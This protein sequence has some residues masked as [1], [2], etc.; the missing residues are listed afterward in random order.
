[1]NNFD[2]QCDFMGQKTS[3]TVSKEH[4]FRR[5]GFPIDYEAEDA[6]L[7]NINWTYSWY[8]A[9]AK[10]WAYVYT[11][12]TRVDSGV[13]YI[14]GRSFNAQKIAKRFDKYQVE[15]A[16]LLLAT[17][18]EEVD[19]QIQQLWKSNYPD[20]SFFLDALA[21]T[22]TESIVKMA[23]QRI[24]QWA[25]LKAMKALSRYS[26][27]YPGW[28][29][30]DQIL[31][32]NIIEQ[33]FDIEKPVTVSESALLYPLKSQIALIGLSKDTRVQKDLDVECVNCSFINC[34]CLKK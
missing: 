10:P 14:N 30:K 19:H 26:P 32:M 18:G 13:F 24:D 17:A 5:L 3:I 31:L 12:S 21:A 16:Q 23:V 22:V 20:R 4:F 7:E 11:V 8:L 15:E 1:M 9:Y 27:G 28:E 6:V 2:L 33:D 25:S 29:L 34:K